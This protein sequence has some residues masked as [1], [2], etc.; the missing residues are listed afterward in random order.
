MK[1]NNFNKLALVCLLFI[2]QI[3]N[4]QS[5]QDLDKEFLEAIQEGA[6]DQPGGKFDEEDEELEKLFRADTSIEN[7]KSILQ[8]LKRRLDDVEEFL[9]SQDPTSDELQRL[10]SN[11]FTSLQASFMPINMPNIGGDYILDVGD[12]L[13]INLVGQENS[14][15][16]ATIGRDGSI[17]LDNIGK[18]YLAGKTFLSAQD[19]IS[20][21]F[22]SSMIGIKPY[23]SLKSIRDIQIVILGGIEAPG[24]YTISGGSNIIGAINA[25]GGVSKKGSFRS[26]QHR[27]N[28]KLIE[29][30]DLY[31]L[32]LDGKFNSLNALRSGDVIF[33]NPYNFGVPIS[34]GIN[35]PSIVELKTG[36]TL[37]NLIRYVGGFSE[38]F[39]NYNSVFLNR[40]GLDSKEIIEVSISDLNSITLQPRDTIVVP[41]YQNSYE[42]LKIVSIEGEVKRPGKYTLQKNETLSELILRA[43]GY[44]EQAYP[45]GAALFRVQSEDKAKEFDAIYYRDTISFI[46]SNLG[47][48]YA[49]IDKSALDLLT[50]QIQASIYTGRMVVEF[51]LDEININSELDTVLL[52]GDRIVVPPMQKFVYL[53]GDIN[54]SATVLPFDSNKGVKD[55]LEDAGGI[56]DTAYSEIFIIDPDGKQ[57][58]LSTKFPFKY[59]ENRS[60]NIFPGTVIYVPKDIGKQDGLTYASTVAPVLSSLALTLASLNSIN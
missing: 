10:G 9:D 58:S 41:S 43:G 13:T 45:F 39:Y 23:I 51:D 7:T 37:D 4:S 20:A 21:I 36:E 25:A 17:F 53:F 29:E 6:L 5:M 56:R 15:T 40:S 28:N 54:T 33:I 32:I 14:S 11:F 19:E 27:R 57:T 24:I 34:G 8:D 52:S 48:P 3:T 18:I 30:I 60:A 55:Y 44:D 16:E 1:T 26:I 59:I 38:G 47:K 42:E 35:N 22:A 49:R 2:S 46:I 12:L 50:E 31:D